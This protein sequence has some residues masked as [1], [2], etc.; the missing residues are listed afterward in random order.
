MIIKVE[1]RHIDAGRKYECM[2]CPIALAIKEAMPD[3]NPFVSGLYVTYFSESGYKWRR[4]LSPKMKRFALAFDHGDKV[5]PCEFDLSQ[6]EVM[7]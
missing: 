4:L 3:S 1:Q 7:Y 6:C 2:F 5:Y